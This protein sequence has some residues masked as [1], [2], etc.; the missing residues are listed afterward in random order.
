MTTVV[1]SPHLDD[2]VLSLG[3]FLDAHTD[4]TVVTVFAGVPAEGTISPYDQA[5]GFT[6][7]ADA[8]RTRRSEDWAAVSGVLGADV[9][10]LPFLDQ[11]YRS[12]PAGWGAIS[13]TIGAQLPPDGCRVLVP[14]GIGHPDHEVAAMAGLAAVRPFVDDVFVYEELPYRVLNPEQVWRAFYGLWPQWQWARFPHPFQQG[15]RAAKINALAQYQS[16]GPLW[17]DVCNLVPERTWHLARI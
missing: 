1:V 16:Q 9:M 11:Q 3:Q 15:R 6:D 2:A 5:C 4:V 12:E 13:E 17:E 14:L 10:H 8:M 7:S